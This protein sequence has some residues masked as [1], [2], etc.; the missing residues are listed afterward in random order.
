MKT[1]IL[2]EKIREFRDLLKEHDDLWGKSLDKTIPD[3]PIKNNDK[4][5][6][7]QIKLARLFYP[8]D[9]YLTQ[10]SMGRLMQHPAT[11]IAWDMYRTAIGDEVAQAKGPSLGKSILEL[12]GIIAILEQ[13]D[14]EKEIVIGYISQQ[15]KRVF[16][17]HG[18]ET[19]ALAKLERFLRGLGITPIIVKHEPSLGKSLD[20][21]VE[22]Q[23][24]TCAAVIILATRDDKIKDGKG[25]EYFQPRPNVI[26]EIGLAQEKVQHKIVYLKEKGCDFP[27]NIAPRVWESFTQD[28][29]EEAFL[30]VVKELKA[31][32]IIQ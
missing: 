24:E 11:G 29:M 15:E 13:E 18:N 28:N 12:E 5:E 6:E 23:M 21:L 19:K 4:L 14:P 8:I 22:N 25:K 26:H 7:Q 16:V 10:F 20:D 1:K 27:S 17:S 30:K 9:R 32:G 31:F 2:L 3:Y